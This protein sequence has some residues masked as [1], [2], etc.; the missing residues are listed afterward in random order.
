MDSTFFNFVKKSERLR[1]RGN[2]RDVLVTEVEVVNEPLGLPVWKTLVILMWRGD[3]LNEI[4]APT[5]LSS[6]GMKET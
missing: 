5:Q 1:D 4:E 3:I 2:G 6:D